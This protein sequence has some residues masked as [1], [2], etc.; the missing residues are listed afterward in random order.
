MATKKTAATKVAPIVSPEPPDDV[1]VIIPDVMEAGAGGT[2]PAAAPAPTAGTTPG[3]GGPEPA[4]TITIAVGEAGYY[5]GARPVETK[6]AYD[7]RMGAS[8]NTFADLGWIL[9]TKPKV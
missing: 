2:A 1:T 3:G 7:A 6:A 9:G 8:A 4:S 5:T